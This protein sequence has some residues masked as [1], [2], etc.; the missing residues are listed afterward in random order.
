MLP[1]PTYNLQNATELHSCQDKIG[2]PVLLAADLKTTI[3][4]E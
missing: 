1:K 2:T 4:D 3:L